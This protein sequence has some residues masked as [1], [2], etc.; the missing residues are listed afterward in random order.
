MSLDFDS[1]ALQMQH[2]EEEYDQEDY[3][4][5]QELQKLLTDLPHDML[6]DS[7]DHLSNFSDC[8]APEEHE[9]VHEPWDQEA[10]WNDHPMTANPQSGPNLYAERFL[11]DQGNIQGEMHASEWPNH[12][13]DEE[14]NMYEI[15]GRA[16]DDGSDDVYLG[17]DGYPA[18]NRYPQ[19]NTYHLP[20]NFRPSYTNGPQQEL[21][22]QHKTANFVDTKKEHLKFGTSETTNSQSVEPY[23]VIYK[24]YQNNIQKPVTVSPEAARRIEAFEDMQQEFLGTGENAPDN[25]QILQL[26]VLN[27][28]KG[29]QLEE[30]NKQLEERA[31]QIRYLSHQLSIVKD[32]KDGMCLSLQESQKLYQNSKEREVQLEGQIKAFETQI[33][34]LAANEEKFIKQAKVAETA[35]ETTQQQLLELRRSDALQRTREQHEA[36]IAALKQK[37]EEQVMSLQEKL[38][39]RLSEL[40]E[41][42]ELCCRLRAH[43]KQLER[44]LEESKLEKNAIINQLSRSLEESQNQCANL[45]Q[46]GLVQETN[47]LRLQLQQAQSAQLISNEMN[48]ALQ[49]ELKELKEEIVLYESAAKHGVFLNDPR[50]NVDVNMTDSYAD[51]GIKKV[52][53]KPRLH[54]EAQNKELD[55]ELCKDEIILELKAEMERLLNSNKTKRDR[56]SQLQNNLNECQRTIEELKQLQK[57]NGQEP[58]GRNTESPSDILQ[59]NISASE[60]NLKEDI[61]RLRKENQVLQQEIESRS[62]H[63]QELDK[64][65]ETLKKVNQDL[66]SQMRQMVQDFDRDKQEAIE[67]YERTYRQHYEDMKKK[68]YEELMEEHAVEKEK[69]IQAYDENIAKLKV[70]IDELNKEMLTVKECYIT[71]C[72]EKDGQ[73]AALKRKFEQEQQLKEENFKKQLLEEKEKS[74]NDLRAELEETYQN[75]VM[76]AKAKW[77]EEKEADIKQRVENE[78]E[79]VKAGWE[80][81]QK[82]IIDQA[83][84]EVEK[85]WQRRLTHALEES[86]RTVVEL[87]DCCSQTQPVTIT[88]ETLS[89]LM[90]KE[91]EKQTLPLQEAL[92]EKERAL[93]EHGASLEMRHRENIAR[94]VEAALT[95]A[96]ARWLQ[97]LTELEEYKTHLKAAQEK[98]EKEYEIKTAKQVSLALSAAEEKWK[99]ELENGDQ[100]RM[101]TKELEEKFLSLK[102][103]L[104]LK[105]EE[106]PAIVK[107]EL[108]KARTLWNKEKQEEVLGIQEQ[109]EKDYHSFLRDHRHQINELL[110]KAKED[111]AKQK[112]ELL[113][114]KEAD[115]KVCLERKWQEW[116]IQEAKRFQN[117]I[118]QYEDRTLVQVELLLDEMHKDLTRCAGDMPAWQAKWR[119]A[120][121]V[122]VNLQFKDRLILCLQKAY[123][124]AAYAILEKTKPAG[125]KAPE[126]LDC[127]SKDPAHPCL[128]S[129]EGETGD[130]ARLSLYDVGE[131][132]ELQRR[133]RKLPSPQETEADNA[134]MFI[135]HWSF[136]DSKCFLS[137]EDFRCKHC[138]QQLERKERECQDLKKKLDKACKHLQLTVKE[139]K[140]KSEQWQENEKMVQTL[141]EENIVMKSQLEEVKPGSVPPRS[142]SEGYVS[143][144]CPSCDGKALEEMRSQYIK[145]VGKIKSDMLRYIHE[146]KERAADIIK[147]EVL[148][149]RQETARKMRKYYLICL[150]QLLIDDGKHDGAEKKII[151]AAGKLAT[152]AKILETPV[153][154]SSQSEAARSALPQNSKPFAEVED[155]KGNHIHQSKQ[156]SAEINAHGR[157]VAKKAYHQVPQ[158]RIPCNLRQ[159]LEAENPSPLSSN[160]LGGGSSFKQLDNVS[161]G[162]VTSTKASTGDRNAHKGLSHATDAAAFH[163]HSP[164]IS[165]FQ[166]VN[167]ASCSDDGSYS[168]GACVMPPNPNERPVSKEF[169]CIQ[170]TRYRKAAPSKTQGFDFQE[171]P[172]KDDRSATDCSL[173]SETLHLESNS[174]SSYPAQKAHP[175]THGK[176]CNRFPMANQ[177][178]HVQEGA[179]GFCQ[180]AS[181]HR[182]KFLVT[183]S[184][185]SNCSKGSLKMNPGLTPCQNADRLSPPSAQQSSAVLCSTAGK[186]YNLLHLRKQIHEMKDFQQDS[187]FDSPQINFD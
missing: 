11:Y 111:F 85:E 68:Y 55:K 47:Q 23:K 46:T 132:V 57:A 163:N 21:S 171:T 151:C 82:E 166:N 42:T 14:R 168:R 59:S 49:E 161:V 128:Q 15:S 69:L 155:P 136:A 94:Q 17:G 48:K 96:H 156:A 184:Q 99:K 60:N 4:R 181:S 95:K 124:N 101:R 10:R 71:V 159:Q 86:K 65:E 137:Q 185:V 153:R 134:P 182:E 24:P 78:V 62:A 29:R 27:K 176:S 72:R 146:S 30:L 28:A 90:A 37:Y 45:L 170:S 131:Q 113:E 18:P 75:S 141:R 115:L 79:R 67:R 114:Q 70:E 183:T 187:G 20:E 130:K 125:I 162:A 35:L 34:T 174:I 74:L 129:G 117:E 92:K 119:T 126:D 81:E 5:E 127:D 142:L 97:E 52:N 152:M 109:N 36:I 116:A 143:K 145:A 164:H 173:V 80:R 43:M 25:M 104:E 19:G 56:V 107:A 91:V 135:S 186:N 31:Q 26:Q 165:E 169:G 172:V 8:S 138:L 148:R 40:Q 112:E 61:L 53:K 103:E 89:Q 6:E 88:D 122:Q 98:W 41:Q 12:N 110:A 2:D 58:Q 63:I 93:R 175:S 87:K 7:G 177:F 106:I 149:E 54:S 160:N 120:P 3:M 84:Q 1:A 77:Q 100:T 150:Q 158:K 66:C 167:L 105:K 123:T 73:E 38:D 121:H 154:N 76:T 178:S 108:A 140:A 50:G 139:H 147:A 33:Q 157:S 133:L 51:L 44:T 180:Q 39:A 32:E 16:S 13:A 102:R 64:N 9:Q 144:P 118:H 22:N 179:S 83:I